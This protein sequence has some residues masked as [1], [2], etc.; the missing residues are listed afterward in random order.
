MR[1]LQC[2]DDR[3]SRAGLLADAITNPGGLRLLTCRLSGQPI[4]LAV[5]FVACHLVGPTASIFGQSVWDSS[6]ELPQRMM[7]LVLPTGNDALFSNDGPAFYQ[8]TDRRMQPGIA[9]AWQG[10][11]YGFVRNFRVTRHGPVYTRFHEGID[12]RSVERASE[13]QE[14]RDLVRSIDEGVVVYVNNTSGQSSYGRYVVVEHWWSGSPFYSLYAH[15]GRIT[16]SIGQNVERGQALGVM[17]YSGVGINRRRAHLHLEVNLMLSRSFQDWYDEYFDEDDR[18]HHGI[19]N[20]MNLA[21]MDVAELYLQ[22]RQD[23]SM[24]IRRFLAGQDPF[25][26]VT[27][28]AAGMPDMLWRYPW[29][30]PDLEGW[31]PMFGPLADFG[32]AWEITFS[33]SGL[34][35]RFEALEHEVTETE[36]RVLNP[37]P[38]PYQY[39]TNGLVRGSG[40][41]ASLSVSGRRHVSLL[42]RTTPDLRG[43]SW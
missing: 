14:P 30:S 22:A 35:L 28:P 26:T 3:M 10:G 7:Q 13:R 39:V 32:S 17:G 9:P 36:V 43:T 21:G 34:P 37:S 25:F 12:I 1:L 15:L 38:M 6:E 27:A 4:S 2:S 40:N 16:A 11:K 5:L 8:Y 18:N 19:Y 20:G 29:L 33:R 24:S 31:S 23:P 42:L 41:E